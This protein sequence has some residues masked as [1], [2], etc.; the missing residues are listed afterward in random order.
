[1]STLNLNNIGQLGAAAIETT[2]SSLSE[3]IGTLS[4]DATA[5]E[6][7]KFQMHLATN[8][9]VTSVYSSVAK[10]RADTLKAVVQKF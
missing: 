7:L 8:S 2:E 5:A 10:E 6:L 1:M 3:L 9:L 4:G